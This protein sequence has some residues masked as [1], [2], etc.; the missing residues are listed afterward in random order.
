MI[1]I[2]AGV[3]SSC[4]LCRRGS[5]MATT[6]IMYKGTCRKPDLARML[7]ERGYTTRPIGNMRI[8]DL[9][10]ALIETDAGH[11]EDDEEDEDSED[12]DSED[13]DSQDED[14]QDGGS[15]DESSHRKDNDEA[16]DNTTALGFMKL[17]GVD[18]DTPEDGLDTLAD[19]KYAEGSKGVGILAAA[20]TSSTLPVTSFVVGFATGV[21]SFLASMSAATLEITASFDAWNTAFKLILEQAKLE[22]KLQA[23]AKAKLL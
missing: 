23:I 14:S 2:Q 13:E 21:N 10:Q 6:E 19:S 17:L 22:R 3:T 12:E 11:T 7:R 9:V 8:K 15:E 20:A 4:Q 1:I 5:T 16:A 18:I